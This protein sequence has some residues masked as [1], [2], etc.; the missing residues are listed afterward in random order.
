MWIINNTVDFRNQPSST[1]ND[2]S[3]PWTSR[4][5]EVARKSY[6]LWKDHVLRSREKREKMMAMD[7][8]K[9]RINEVAIWL[10]ERQSHVQVYNFPRH[11][12]AWEFLLKARYRED[13]ENFFTSLQLEPPR[14]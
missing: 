14:T 8:K 2:E 6:E 3:I 5:Q 10:S 11:S 1:R 4:Q 13:R 9:K 12:L 7:P